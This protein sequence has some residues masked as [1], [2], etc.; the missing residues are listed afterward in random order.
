MGQGAAALR[1][2]GGI[3]VGALLLLLALM[4]GRFFQLMVLRHDELRDRST[5]QL[6]RRE[7]VKAYR[8][9]ILDRAGRELALTRLVPSVAVDPGLVAPSD[10]DGLASALAGPLGLAPEEVRAELERPCNFRWL[11]RRVLSEDAIRAVR[12]IDHCAIIVRD[13]L[14]RTHP[15][16]VVG[17][18]LVGVTKTEG[19]GISGAEQ[20]YDEVLSP[21]FGERVVYRDGWT[22]SR[23]ISAPGGMVRAERNGEDVVLAMDLTIQTF[24]ENALDRAVAKWGP[25]AAVVVV[26]DPRNG[27]LL[28]AASRPGFHPDRRE[29]LTKKAARFGVVSDAYEVGSTMKPLMAAAALDAG[30]VAESDQFDCT[31]SGSRRIY[32]A[33]TLHDHKALGRRSFA[34]VIIYSSNSAISNLLKN[35]I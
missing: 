19:T 20:T 34:E 31:T 10:R 8:G 5:T 33:R 2:R 16:G 25:Q 13:E 27:D 23:R 1:V 29:G 11:R 18:H 15:A 35:N 4:A 17:A 21:H 9:R 7:E 6:T 22:R 14:C 26:L 32:G 3:L 12:A 24:A 30:A 28:A